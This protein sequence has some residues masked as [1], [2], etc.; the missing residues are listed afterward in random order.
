M[1]N[2]KYG[3]NLFQLYENPLNWG[4]LDKADLSH[5]D[6]NV[7]CGDFIHI[8]LQLGEDRRISDVKWSGYG[9]AICCAAAS[10]LTE[11]I[12]GMSLKEAAAFPSEVLLTSLD[13]SFNRARRQCALLPLEVLKKGIRQYTYRLAKR[14]V[15]QPLTPFA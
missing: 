5:E 8:G 13:I 2:Q 10:R 9:C 14:Q 15:S 1:N 7:L 6:D 4:L 11:S 12:K 3:E